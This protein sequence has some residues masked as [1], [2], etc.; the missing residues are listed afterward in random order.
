MQIKHVIGAT[1]FFGL[2]ALVAWAVTADRYE[3]KVNEAYLFGYV[4]ADTAATLKPFRPPEATTADVET[5][6]GDPNQPSL[7]EEWTN[8]AEVD[9][10]EQDEVIKFVDEIDEPDTEPADEPSFEHETPEQTRRNLQDIIDK[11]TANPQDRDEFV[12]QAILDRP[13]HKPPYVISRDE[14]AYGED[15]ESHAK[16]T[17]TYYPRDRVLL[18]D[19]DDPIEDIAEMIGWRSLSNFGGVSGDPDV[20]FVRNDRL[21]SDY[22]VVKEEDAPLPLHVKYGM[23]KEEFKLNK[24]AGT[25]KL[26]REDE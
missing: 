17:L 18:D 7:L 14:Y 15:G 24:A 11:Y 21:M 9:R 10:P 5:E 19:D 6:E 16:I 2:G 4:G 12:N 13:D 22:E 8:K 23:G 20:V 25:L 1:G 26:R 3:L